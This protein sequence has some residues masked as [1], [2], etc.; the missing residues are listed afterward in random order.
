MPYTS[1][2]PPFYVTAD[3]VVLSD[4]T[5]PSVL[6]VRRGAPPYEGR[7]AIPGGFVDPDESLD[8]AARRELAEETGVD[9]GDAIRFEQLGA[10]GAP[11]RDPRGRIVSV[12]YLAVVRDLP[13][14]RAGDDAAEAGWHRA[15]SLGAADLAFDHA[16]ILADALIRARDEAT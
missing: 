14:V 6:L 7:L 8:A 12:A 16:H 2:Y 13:G 1:E 4:D 10:Y 15:G 11:D 9:A 5:D 3:M